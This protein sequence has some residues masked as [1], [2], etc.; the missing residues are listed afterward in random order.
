MGEDG[1]LGCRPLYVSPLLYLSVRTVACS[2]PPEA[3]TRL[4]SSAAR[5]LWAGAPRAQLRAS[6]H[7]ADS[8]G[9]SQEEVAQAI[10]HHCEKQTCWASCS[11]CGGE[12]GTTRLRLV[13]H[14]TGSAPLPFVPRLTE[15]SACSAGQRTGGSAARGGWEPRAADEEDPSGGEQSHR[16]GG[17]GR[18]AAG[19]DTGASLASPRPHVVA[20]RRGQLQAATPAARRRGPPQAHRG[21]QMIHRPRAAC[22]RSLLEAWDASRIHTPLILNARCIPSARALSLTVPPR[23]WTAGAFGRART[24]ARTCV[25]GVAAQRSAAQRIAMRVS[26]APRRLAVI[27]PP[28]LPRR[29]HRRG[30][31]ARGVPA[32]SRAARRRDGGGAP[33]ACSDLGQRWGKLA[34]SKCVRRRS[35]F[36]MHHAVIH[37]A[38]APSR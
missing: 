3:M 7:C 28:P 6:I 10:G 17:P 21:E 11:R 18:E 24:I 38:P 32:A 27:H 37:A 12:S 23:G 25:R 20:A 22:G 19:R 14:R 30:G 29:R 34:A 26:P 4:S 33:P 31:A 15:A 2:W 5:S 8:G 13:S 1:G 16:D 35:W 36:R 9:G